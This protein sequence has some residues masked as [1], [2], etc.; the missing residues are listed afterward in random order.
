[1]RYEVVN[2]SDKCYISSDVPFA[3]AVACI[4]LGNGWYGLKDEKG[5]SFLHP[6]Q[7]LEDCFGITKEET[8]KLVEKHRK[9]VYEC[10]TTFEYA[11]EP[12][13]ANNI[14]AAAKYHAEILK[15]Y[16]DEE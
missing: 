6:M 5:E 1:M 8:V 16:L 15:K 4:L 14:A 12:T 11:A 10:L 9:D 13:S 3:A 7:T 2:F